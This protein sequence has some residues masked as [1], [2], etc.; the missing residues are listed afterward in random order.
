MR[1]VLA[2]TVALLI[3]IVIAFHVSN[4]FVRGY[5]FKY[6]VFNDFQ[7][8][9]PLEHDLPF[10]IKLQSLDNERV[11]FSFE[12]NGIGTYGMIIYRFDSVFYEL[13][14][15]KLFQQTRLKASYDNFLS[16]ESSGFDCGTGLGLVTINPLEN[17]SIKLSKKALLDKFYSCH[18]FSFRLNNQFVDL[19][20]K[21]SIF[22]RNESNIS[23]NSDL[24][25]DTQDSMKIQLFIPLYSLI[26]GKE[27]RVYSNEIKV[28]YKDIIENFKNN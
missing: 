11:S 3:G 22:H 26:S 1:N 25:L 15:D 27:H 21:E 23:I 9:E 13:T 12:N 6:F 8:G 16:E 17:Y 19:V 24:K 7:I 14:S 18:Q 28:S 5:Y 10:V 20:N 4:Y 2:A